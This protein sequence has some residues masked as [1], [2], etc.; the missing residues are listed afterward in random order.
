[1]NQSSNVMLT[2]ETPSV[3]ARFVESRM[4]AIF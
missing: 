1:V 4:N 3:E 2:A